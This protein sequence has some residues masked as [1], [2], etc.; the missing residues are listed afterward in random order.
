MGV[1]NVDI[2][3][4][5]VDLGRKIRKYRKA[6]NMTQEQLADRIGM[7]TSNISHIE[8]ATT[9]VSLQAL[10]RIANTLNV[11]I[12]Q[13]LCDSL[14]MADSYLDKD[15]AQI[16]EGCSPKEKKIVRNIIESTI[17]SLREYN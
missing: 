16:L 11:S 3:L 9:Q 1:K 17:K 4:N 15:I 13:L 8:R 12:D 2:E 7:A 14:S 10:V 5:Y 6:A